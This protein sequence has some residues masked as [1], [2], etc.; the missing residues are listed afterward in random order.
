MALA[1]L[2]PKLVSVQDAEM[3]AVFYEIQYLSHFGW[4]I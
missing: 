2:I 1:K 3:L 4:I